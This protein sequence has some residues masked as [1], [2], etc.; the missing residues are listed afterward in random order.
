VQT[1]RDVEVQRRDKNLVDH[2]R[3]PAKEGD[4]EAGDGAPHSVTSYI[5]CVCPRMTPGRPIGPQARAPLLA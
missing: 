2:G 4:G 1:W 3:R 5:A